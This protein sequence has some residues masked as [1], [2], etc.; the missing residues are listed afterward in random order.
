MLSDKL[1]SIQASYAAEVAYR[2]ALVEERNALLQATHKVLATLS[3]E[4]QKAG[5]ARL[6]VVL[7]NFRVADD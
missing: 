1:A 6:F 2:I 5:R 4:M 7:N 3:T